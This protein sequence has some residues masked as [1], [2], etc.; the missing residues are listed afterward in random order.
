M[1]SK[2]IKI[3]PVVL[4]LSIP[5]LLLFET[6]REYFRLLTGQAGILP[7]WANVIIPIVIWLVLVHIEELGQGKARKFLSKILI[8][9]VSLGLI[10]WAT[11]IAYDAFFNSIMSIKPD[12]FV[13][14][15]NIRTFAKTVMFLPSVV[16]GSIIGYLI[17]ELKDNEAIKHLLYEYRFSDGITFTTKKDV[18]DTTD[19]DKPDL[20]L[21]DD[22][23]SK[24]RVKI[25][26]FDCFRHL[27]ILGPTG[28]GKTSLIL[29]R[30]ALQLVR[31]K[32]VGLLVIDPKG[33]FAHYVVAMSRFFKRKYQLLDPTM[34]DC[35]YFNPFVGEESDVIENMVT[36]FLMTN[37]S[38]SYFRDQDERLTRNAV[39]LLKRLFGD[40][41]TFLKLNDLVNNIDGF[42]FKCMNML[43]NLPGDPDFVRQNKETVAYFR[44]SYFNENTRFFQDTSNLRN[45]I[46][47][48]IDNKYL[49]KILNPPEG[50]GSDINFT[51]F[52]EDG[53]VISVSLAQGPLR[54]L[55]RYFGLF[56][57]MNFQAAVFSRPLPEWKRRP[58]YEIIDEMQV[59][60]N[61]QLADMFQQARSL[62]CMVIPATQ[63]LE[64]VVLKLGNAGKAFLAAL[65]TNCQNRVLFA[66][67][68]PED[69]K[70]FSDW[71]GIKKVE[72]RSKGTSRSTFSLFHGF[73]KMRAPT[74]TETI[75]EQDEAVLSIDDIIYTKA[76]EITYFTS[77]NMEIQRPRIGVVDWIDK[78]SHD[79]FQKMVEDQLK[80][81]SDKEYVKKILNSYKEEEKYVPE[82]QPQANNEIDDREQ[83]DE[84]D[85]I[86]IIENESNSKLELAAGNDFEPE[87]PEEEDIVILVEEEEINELQLPEQKTETADMKNQKEITVGKKEETTNSMEVI[88]ISNKNLVVVDEEDPLLS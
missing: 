83:V 50:K 3:N 38:S 39:R 26:F 52:L 32:Q 29:I 42:G 63:S 34:P 78:D 57:Q 20:E 13:T 5:V 15:T 88:S 18:Q 60:A 70:I 66:G 67:L 58:C 41:A 16:T 31:N 6:I 17:Y 79:I 10:K 4:F 47:N 8:M 49:R 54:R 86:T 35:P 27:L 12:E 11:L 61:E 81:V 33:D 48:I 56:V 23:I 51:K 44:D 59:V 65:K 36:I 74:K 1:E 25:P 43:T 14:T 7:G 19:N 37:D 75:T 76:K 64:Q 73:D 85:V 30:I 22:K 87:Y 62:R 72:K 55:A 9:S 40:D 77:Q 68:P 24:K 21:C 53:G 84:A 2:T 80:G 46:A 69:A 45:Q 71:S 82:Y 28:C